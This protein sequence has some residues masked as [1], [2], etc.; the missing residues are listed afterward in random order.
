[1]D[2]SKQTTKD[3]DLL[4]SCIQDISSLSPSCQQFLKFLINKQIEES[5]NNYSLNFCFIEQANDESKVKN[6]KIIY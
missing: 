1:M 4:I 2:K 6:V 5:M 3:T